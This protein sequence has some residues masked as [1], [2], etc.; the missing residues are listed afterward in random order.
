MLPAYWSGQNKGKYSTFVMNV[1]KHAKPL[2]QSPSEG[3]EQRAL[4]Q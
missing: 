1:L 3:S 2:V 4:E